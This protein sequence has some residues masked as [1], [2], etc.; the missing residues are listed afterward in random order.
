MTEELLLL[1]ARL[2]WCQCDMNLLKSE[3]NEN[4]SPHVNVK[5]LKVN[6]LF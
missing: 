2:Q 6:I 4:A 1:P 3:M 5:A